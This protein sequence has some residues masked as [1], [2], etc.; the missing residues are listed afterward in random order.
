MVKNAFVASFAVFAL[1]A[2]GVPDSEASITDTVSGEPEIV[3]V[4][5]DLSSSRVKDWFPLNAG[6]EWVFEGSN[7]ETKTI[8]ISSVGGGI[9]YVTGLHAEGKW[10]GVAPSVPNTLYAWD[11]NQGQWNVF[12]RFGYAVTP[13]TYKHSDSGCE[14][15]AAKRASTGQS[16]TT[17]GGTFKDTRSI[18]FS[19]VG[20]ANLRCMQGDFSEL[21]FAAKVG[22]VFIRKA[23]GTKYALKTAKVGPV[24]YPATTGSVLVKTT[25]D[26]ASYVNQSNT[27]RC[28][29]TPCPSNEV[30]AEAKVTITIVNTTSQTQ[31]FR[32]NSGCQTNVEIIDSAGKVVT[33]TAI[34]RMCSMALTSFTLSPGA[35]KSWSEA[36]PLIS[37]AG[38]QLRGSY[39]VKGS[40]K[41]ASSS[42]TGSLSGTTAIN[43]SLL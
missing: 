5:Q 16:Y 38:E 9:A 28:I 40:V 21:V 19:M 10:V 23:D 2:C 20:G 41:P 25:T 33:N 3:E 24:T 1:A 15:F 13:W 39:T 27:I 30:S 35:T 43:V 4:G 11:S 14:T 32:F 36:V 22:P 37:D 34:S 12:I 6:N 29:T 17:D 18:S 8:R 26:K 7:D 42:W 31:S